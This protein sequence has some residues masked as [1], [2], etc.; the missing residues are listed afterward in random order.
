MLCHEQT[1]NLAIET[2]HGSNFDYYLYSQLKVKDCPDTT[3]I[4]FISHCNVPTLSNVLFINMTNTSILIYNWHKHKFVHTCKTACE[5]RNSITNTKT[6]SFKYSQR[7]L[8]IKERMAGVLYNLGTTVC[9]SCVIG[10]QGEFDVCVARGF[11]CRGQ[12][13]CLDHCKHRTMSSQV[14]MAS[15]WNVHVKQ[16]QGIHGLAPR[17]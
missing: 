9:A 4:S 7:E 10:N 5:E 3:G 2:V 16:Q 17:D 15:S 11:T 8:F 14:H 6:F 13:T 12:V 1:Y